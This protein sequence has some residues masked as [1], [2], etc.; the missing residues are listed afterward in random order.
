[1]LG[2]SDGTWDGVKVGIVLGVSEGRRDSEGDAEGTMVGAGLMVGTIARSSTTE[3]VD[4]LSP[5]MFESRTAP[6]VTAMAV[7]TT[8]AAPKSKRFLVSLSMAG[9]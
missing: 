3:E 9:S 6:Q 8:A 4:V 2:R 7:H 1:M 5:L